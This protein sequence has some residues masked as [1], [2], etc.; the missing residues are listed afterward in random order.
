MI[1]YICDKCGKQQDKV[2]EDV[3]VEDF[4]EA[5]LCEA[6]FEE[7]NARVAAVLTRANNQTTKIRQ[8]YLKSTDDSVHV[9]EWSSGYIAH[10]NTKGGKRVSTRVQVC[11]LGCHET[12]KEILEKGTR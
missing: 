9:H 8:E 5:S 4:E 2:M 6:C 7:L 12:K 1:K 11:M 3:A 10:S